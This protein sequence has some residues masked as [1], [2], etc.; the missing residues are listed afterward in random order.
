MTHL[1]NKTKK[2][3]VESLTKVIKLYKSRNFVVTDVYSDNEFDMDDLKVDIQP[4]KLHVCSA[5]EHVPMVERPIRTIKEK[6]RTICHSVP[7]MSYTRLMTKS[8]IMTVTKWM[9][10]FPATGGVTGSY[11][12]SNILE[13]AINPD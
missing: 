3:V 10:A 6:A 1:Q 2:F 4:A 12:P 5:N 8:L 13:G 9:N 11:S 7:Y